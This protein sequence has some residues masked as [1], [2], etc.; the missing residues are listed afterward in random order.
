M[1]A[2]WEVSARDRRQG[3]ANALREIGRAIG[4][5]RGLVDKGASPQLVEGLKKIGDQL[6]ADWVKRAGA[7]GEAAVAAYKK[8]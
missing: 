7:E 3:C 1:Y 4:R 6:T 5:L 8:M 2:R